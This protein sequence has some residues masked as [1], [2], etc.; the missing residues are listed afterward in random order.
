[1]NQKKMMIIEYIEN[2]NDNNIVNFIWAIIMG[3]KEKKAGQ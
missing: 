1:M 3:Y 2:T